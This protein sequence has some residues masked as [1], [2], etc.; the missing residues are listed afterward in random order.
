M[1]FSVRHSLLK[2]SFPL[3]KLFVNFKKKRYITHFLQLTPCL[4]V[5]QYCYANL[6]LCLK[7][8]LIKTQIKLVIKILLL[9]PFGAFRYSWLYFNMFL[10]TVE[11]RYGSGF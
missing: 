1:M 7:D 2:L 4:F 10:Q 8:M 6:E 9:T 5:F 3:V 11:R